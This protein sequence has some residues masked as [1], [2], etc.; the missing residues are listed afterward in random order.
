MGGARKWGGTSAS[1]NETGRHLEGSN[2]LMADGHVKWFRGSQVSSGRGV[3]FSK[4]NQDNYPFVTGCSGGG[5]PPSVVT[6]AWAAGID[7]YFSDGVTK[8]AV[9]FSMR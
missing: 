7:G 9:T 2:F 4:C 1:E 8:P 5:N 3:S 6:Y